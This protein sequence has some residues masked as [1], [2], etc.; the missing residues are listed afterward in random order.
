MV[1][2]IYFTGA[3]I[4]ATG[5]NLYK[6]YT[7]SSSIS[8]YGLY[9]K[10]LVD[11]RVSDETTMGIMA[12][13]ILDRGDTPETRTTLVIRDNNNLDGRGYDIESIHPGQ[14]I[15]LL[16]YTQQNTNLWNT[17]IWDTDKWDYDLTQV[18]STVQQIMKV[19]YEPNKLTVELSS[20]LPDISHRVEDIRRNQISLTTNEN[21]TAPTT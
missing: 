21:S 8:N 20:K 3:E 14:T 15:K 7:R 19:S 11:T 6:K 17:A 16:G 13:S 2:K 1:N 9:A 10:K 18:S 5:E 4:T 12:T